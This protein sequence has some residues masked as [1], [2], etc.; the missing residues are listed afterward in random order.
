[1]H[2]YCSGTRQRQVARVLTG[3][4]LATLCSHGYP[5]RPLV[6]S[7]L[8][9]MTGNPSHIQS[10]QCLLCWRQVEPV[11]LTSK[12]IPPSQQQQPKAVI[13][14]HQ[15]HNNNNNTASSR[16]AMASALEGATLRHVF[17]F[18]GRGNFLFFG[19]V[20]K[21][22]LQSYKQEFSTT[23]TLRQGFQ[24]VTCGAR[25]TLLHATVTSPAQFRLAVACGLDRW[26]DDMN[27]HCIAGA[28]ADVATLM[29]AHELGMPYNWQVV[30]SAVKHGRVSVVQYLLE[31][32]KVSGEA[33]E[34]LHYSAAQSGSVPMLRYLKSQ[35]FEFNKETCRETAESGHLAA[36]KYL[37]EEAGC[38]W[39]AY[40][41]ANKAARGGSMEMLQW[42][43]QQPGT[44][45]TCKA[46][47]WAASRGDVAMCEFLHSLQC[48]MDESACE[49]AIIGGHLSTLRWLRHRGCPWYSFKYS[50]VRAASHGLV[51]IMEYLLLQEPAPAQLLTDMLNTAGSAGKLAAAVWLREQHSAEWPP[52]LKYKGSSLCGRA[53]RT[54]SG[55]VLAWARQQQCTS[56]LH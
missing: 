41:I 29:A 14:K 27:L 40:H 49:H 24:N 54:W 33:I 25:T 1:M 11:Y 23:I 52:V 51:D 37:R 15:Q 44:R 26:L 48:P 53:G 36:L 55:E 18:V 56:P 42:C 19:P 20:S 35:G 2:V 30:S 47:K 31:T 38:P 21:G 50:C 4:R 3:A 7:T 10:V 28:Q 6:Y 5:A 22:W 34:H 46:M 9:V 45:A 13:I 43:L 39:H 17:G 32:V 8:Q 12:L 16:A